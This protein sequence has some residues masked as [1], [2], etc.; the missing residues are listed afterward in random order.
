[1]LFTCTHWAAFIV[2]VVG[3]V[4]RCWCWRPM[5]TPTTHATNQQAKRKNGTQMI[6]KLNAEASPPAEAS[7]ATA[8][9]SALR[10]AVK[11]TFCVAFRSEWPHR[12]QNWQL[13]ALALVSIKL[14]LLLL[15]LLRVENYARR[16]VR[17]CRVSRDKQERHRTQN[18]NQKSETEF[19]FFFFRIWFCVA[20]FL[21]LFAH[22]FT[23]VLAR[24]FSTLALI[25]VWRYRTRRQALAL[26]L[27]LTTANTVSWQRLHASGRNEWICECAA[28]TQSWNVED[29]WNETRCAPHSHSLSRTH[30]LSPGN[31]NLPT[32]LTVAENINSFCFVFFCLLLLFCFWFLLLRER[33]LSCGSVTARPRR[34]FENPTRTENE[35]G[36]NQSCLKRFGNWDT[37]LRSA[38]FMFFPVVLATRSSSG[39]RWVRA[40]ASTHACRSI[41]IVSH[42]ARAWKVPTATANY[43]SLQCVSF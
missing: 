6:F 19:E 43:G 17:I 8:T 16:A 40:R 39:Q 27:A 36:K 38:V 25:S 32:A 11:V 30:A 41:T 15:W 2:V 31:C 1:M 26:A 28:K 22:F 4:K 14:L 20:F 12:R 7:A 34:R 3:L 37:L 5:T 24:S 29:A 18:A 13:S 10:R 35:I 21:I 33:R 42:C 9:A 23:C